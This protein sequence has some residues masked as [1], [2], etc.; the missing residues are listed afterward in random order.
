MLTLFITI[1]YSLDGILFPIR[2][3]TRPLNILILICLLYALA[4]QVTRNSAYPFHL[5]AKSLGLFNCFY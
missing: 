1:F 4:M 5:V 3:L 2:W